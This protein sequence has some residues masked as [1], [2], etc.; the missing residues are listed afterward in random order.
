MI[1]VFRG[2]S[3]GRQTRGQSTQSVSM[4]AVNKVPLLLAT[5]WSKHTSFNLVGVEF[6][7]HD[8]TLELRSA[9]LVRVSDEPGA[10]TTDYCCTFTAKGAKERPRLGH[11]GF[12]TSSKYRESSQIRSHI[13]VSGI[14]RCR[15]FFLCI[16]RKQRNKK[17]YWLIISKLREKNL[18]KIVTSQNRT[19]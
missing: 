2:P 3:P 11:G 18:K 14:R 16:A 4:S 12:Y 15:N 19:V 5:T 6:R 10:G 7:R 1:T 13:V 8:A 9:W 17:L